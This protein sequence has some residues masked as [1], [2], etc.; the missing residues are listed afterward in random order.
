I[1]RDFLLS[2]L[3]QSEHFM[4]IV[5]Y[6]AWRKDSELLSSLKALKADTIIVD[7]SHN[8]MHGDTGAAHG[9]HELVFAGNYCPGCYTPVVKKV[10]GVKNWAKCQSCNHEDYK[11]IFSTVQRVIPISGTGILN[12]PQ[13]LWSQLHIVDPA[14][15]HS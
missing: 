2:S 1:E 10:N 3:A 14:N 7:E 11:W 4:L 15:F 12:K 5:N 9:V 13:D 6:E 8:I